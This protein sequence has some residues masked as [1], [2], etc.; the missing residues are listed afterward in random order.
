MNEETQRTPVSNQGTPVS[1]QGTSSSNQG[2]PG[3]PNV[4]EAH[5]PKYTEPRSILDPTLRGTKP[6]LWDLERESPWHRAAA[7]CFAL[8]ASAREVARRLGKSEPAV[9]NL[10]R[11][12]WFQ[13]EVTA[14]MAEY[15][16]RDVATL[17]AAEQYNSLATLVEIRDNPK[18][19]AAARIASARDILDRAL[20][21]PTQRIEAVGM[22]V[23]SDPVAEV[24]QLSEEISRLKKDLS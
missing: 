13:G 18:V 4:S 14:I 2:T 11:Q 19:P 3:K 6:P 12:P 10:L 21:K 17:F 24:A 23:S 15:G 9:Q 20:G 1:N 8:G 22:P 7:F 5:I 16:H